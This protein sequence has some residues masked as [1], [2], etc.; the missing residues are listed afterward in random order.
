[1]GLLILSVGL[2]RMDSANL[3][4]GEASVAGLGT[5]SPGDSS[6]EWSIEHTASLL[7]LQYCTTVCCVLQVVFS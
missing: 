7:L 4:L 6:Q 2:G 1:M 5:V 3:V